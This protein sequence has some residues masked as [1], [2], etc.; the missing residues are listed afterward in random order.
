M[1]QD[2]TDNNFA[3]IH[4]KNDLILTYYW[5]RCIITEKNGFAFKYYWQVGYIP[6]KS[7]EMRVGLLTEIVWGRQVCT[8][9]SI[10]LYSRNFYFYWLTPTLWFILTYIQETFTSIGLLQH[11]DFYWL[12]NIK[13]TFTSIGLLQQLW[14]LLTYIQETFTCIGLLQQLWFLLTYIQ[15]TFTCIGLL[16]QPWF[17]LL[18]NIKLISRVTQPALRYFGHVVRQKRWMDND[19]MLGEMSGKRR[20]GR[21]KAR[22]LDNVN[23]IKGPFTHKSTFQLTAWDGTPES[24]QHEEVLPRLSP[25]V[26][27][28][29]TT[30]GDKIPG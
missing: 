29:S 27:H 12:I 25:G 17:L 3:A 16:Q 8:L 6:D 30:Q 14:F 4:H 1:F 22:W 13:E 11:F 7:D 18:E 2:N 10:D 24:E 5:Q 20:R 21:P 15:E 9:I 19:V 26:G 28:D 23:S